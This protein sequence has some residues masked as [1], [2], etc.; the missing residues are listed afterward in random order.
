MLFVFNTTFG[1]IRFEDKVNI[2]D[3]FTVSTN[4]IYDDFDND[5]DLDII[6]H[7]TIN[8]SNVLLQK[9]QNGIFN[10]DPSILIDSGKNPIISLDLNNDGFP[11][12]ITY[13]Q[14][15]KIGV[16]YNLQNDSFSNEEIVQSFNGSY[17]IDPI[18]VDY[19]SDGFMDLVVI[20]NNEDAYLLL[21]NQSGGLKPAEFL[22]PVGTFNFIYKIDD[23]DNDGDLDFY[24]WDYNKIKIHLYDENIKDFFHPIA[25]D[26]TSS[27]RSF[28]ILD[29]DGNGF[30]DILYF[31]DGAIW[32]KY[33]DLKGGE[34]LE[35]DEY[36]VLKDM[37][38]VDNISLNANSHY[39]VHVENNE[40]GMYSVYIAG[41]TQNQ[42]NIYKFQIQDGVFGDVEI[43]LA[44]FE[45]NSLSLS[46]FKFLDLN[47]DDSID[48]TFTTSSNQ[49]DMILINHNINDPVDKT[50]CIQQA[51]TPNDF[52]V[53]DMNG[54]GV[55]DL[56]VGKS[57]L[58]FF[59]KTPN[60]ELSEMQNLI[61]VEAN[62]NTVSYPNYN[63][64]DFNND[65]IGDVIDFES[66]TDSVK[67]FKN[68]G[69]DNF[70][71]IQSLNL[72]NN[73][74]ATDVYFADI[75]GDFYKDLIFYN[76]FDYTYNS[77]IYWVKNI[78]GVD[79]GTLQ[80]L[81][82]NGVETISPVTFAFDDFNNDGETD[83]LILNYYFQENGEWITEVNLLENQGAK[84]S[85]KSLAKFTGDYANSNLK[86]KDFDQDGDL[87]FF[88][89]NIDT[90]QYYD[91]P[92]LFFKNDGQNNFD[93]IMIENLNIEDVEFYDNDGDGLY[94][95]YAW[96]YDV[97]SYKNNIFYYRTTDYLNFHK[98]EIDSYTAYYDGSSR[99]SRGDIV[100]FD[101]NNDDKEDLF[102][103]NF[104]RYNGLISVYQNVSETLGVQEIRSSDNLNQLKIY[105][106][107]FVNSVSWN[108][109]A[110]N[111]YNVKLFSQ[112]GK[113][114]FEKNTSENNLDLSSFN[115]GVYFF[116]IKE[117]KFGFER[118]YK[119]I[120]K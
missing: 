88:V 58:G 79:F 99:R 28:G 98:V 62:P 72:P 29:L 23:F 39:E 27:L 5:N 102:I 71:F 85:G 113:L 109:S 100:L 37:M 44:N 18:K 101:Y 51:I 63:I 40:N 35:E 120:K 10:I 91:Y 78:D 61:G 42:S 43:V 21:N 94:E 33:F 25:L 31:K 64:I 83:I 103:D 55:E 9:N 38:V 32:A 97:K 49:N 115:S 116:A 57:G 77:G 53:I 74:F 89:Y 107:P 68:S 16:L 30:K 50:I 45:L 7:G 111:I 2:Y 59:E 67:L 65:G 80:P 13:R 6:K 110:N 84:F 70:E 117:S 73:F 60:N 48:F 4:I 106:N 87:D 92:L 119:I 82:I 114:I 19:N 104:S 14:F 17:T 12:L 86:I 22:I 15:D 69:N 95:I 93:S 75:D 26:C 90:N 54:D 11:D 118:I 81:I 47:N 1:Q 96:N 52:S 46:Q 41:N 108:S 66:S 34:D 36:I 24:I 56:C 76:T 8:S 20:N 3:F 105:P 112:D